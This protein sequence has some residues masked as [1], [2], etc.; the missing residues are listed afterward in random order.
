VAHQNNKA[1]FFHILAYLMDVALCFRNA[2]T[3]DILDQEPVAVTPHLPGLLPRTRGWLIDALVKYGRP[4]TPATPPPHHD[5]ATVHTIAFVDL[6]AQPPC[7]ALP[8]TCAV[9]WRHISKARVHFRALARAMAIIVTANHLSHI[10]PRPFVQAVNAARALFLFHDSVQPTLDAL[11]RI[12]DTTP[13][14]AKPATMRAFT[15]CLKQDD[16]VHVLM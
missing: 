6:I 13:T 14:D 15:Q 12:D 11:K 3:A 2:R 4:I 1:F 16:P 10:N 5:F 8:E 9:E 7:A